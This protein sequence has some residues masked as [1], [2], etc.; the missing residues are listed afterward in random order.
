[1]Q[2]FRGAIAAYRNP[3]SHRHIEFA[4]PGEAAE[5]LLL[6]NLLLRITDRASAAAAA[7]A[8]PATAGATT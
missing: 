6:A 4:D 8:A 3:V 5:V 1:M 7:S 2:L